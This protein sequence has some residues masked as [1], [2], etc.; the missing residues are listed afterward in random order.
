MI[1]DTL[2]EYCKALNELCKNSQ[3]MA[4]T[5]PDE[6]AIRAL[7]YVQ[8][9]QI[10]TAGDVLLFC[11][12][13]NLMN[14]YVKQG[15]HKKSFGYFFKSYMRRLTDLLEKKSIEGVGMS[16]QR[17]GNSYVTMVS[18]DDLQ[19]SFHCVP[20]S[21]QLSRRSS[22]QIAFDG[23]RK[24]RCA[25]MLFSAIESEPQFLSNRTTEGGEL[26]RDHD[27]AFR[28]RIAYPR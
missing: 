4:E 3:D 5:I 12:A 11:S 15:S 9:M 8:N 16:T 10:S 20:G 27:G 21:K 23:I 14:T 18:I 19:F 25:S 17:D 28:N 24:Q 7:Y 2:T 13:V 6:E 22:K 1:K 26:M